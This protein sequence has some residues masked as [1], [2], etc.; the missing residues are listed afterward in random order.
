MGA[1]GGGLLGGLFGFKDGGAVEAA[2][3]G[4]IR[5]PG[6]AT[7]DSIPARLSDGEFIVN[8]AAT[9]RNL[10]LLHAIN[11]GEIAAFAAGGLA[12]DRPVPAAND[13][14]RAANDNAPSVTINAPV[15]VNASGGTPEQNADLA[16]QMARQMERSLRGL[17][18]DE[19]LKQTRQGNILNSRSR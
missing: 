7:S 15:T 10:D 8:A 1:G 19:L 6:T 17:V 14:R 16:K 9:R 18:T 2:T 13:N 4:L 3:G 12:G 5:G 11:R